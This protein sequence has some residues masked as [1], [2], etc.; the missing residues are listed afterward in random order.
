MPVLINQ[1][2]QLAENLPQESADQA[3]ASGSHQIPLF[4][5]DG[6]PVTAPINDAQHLLS[7]GYTQPSPDQLGDLLKHAKYSTVPEQIKTGLEGAASAAT[8]GASTGVERALGVNPED[9]QG[10]RETNPG[11]HTIGQMGGLVG[12][13][14]LAPEVSV[15]KG[16]T[17]TGEG[18]AAALGLGAEGAGLASRMAGG[19]VKAAV[20]N[21]LFQSGDEVSKLLSSDPHQSVE[22]AMSEIGLG[23]LIGAGIGAP[24]GAVSPLWKA[25]K[26]THLGQFLEDFK[27]RFKARLENPNPAEALTEEVSNY[28]KSVTSMA[29]EVYGA[30]GL[31]SRAIAEHLPEMSAKISEQV[32]G[33]GSK[34][35]TAIK[36]LKESEDPFAPRLEKSVS[37]WQSAVTDPNA[38]S[39]EIFDATQDLKQQLQEW[40]KYNKALA[41][42]SE[43]EFRDTAKGLAFELRTAL[44][45]SAVWGKSADVQKGINSAFKEYLPA[46]K[47]FEKRFTSL[48][49][50]ERVVDPGKINTY[51]NQ[52]GKPNAELKQEMLKN[53]IDASEKYKKVIGDTHANLGLE[54]P[55]EHS[56]LEHS[57]SSLEQVTPG[58]KLADALIN[59]GLA[60]LAGDTT[61]AVI[62]G[63]IGHTV[64]AGGIGA[65]IGEHA[66]GPFLSSVLPSIVKPLLEKPVFGEAFK[67]AVDLGVSVAK[68]EAALSKAA[69]A[70]FKSGQ[71]VIPQASMASTKARD[72]LKDR[73][74]DL[75]T[76]VA[77]LM[78]T[79]GQTGY[80]MPDHGSAMSTVAARSVNYLQSLKPNEEK[81]GP[82]DPPRQ[83]SQVEISKYNRALDIAEQPLSA[84]QHIKDGTLT[85][86]DVLTFKNLYPS[87]Y[88]SMSQKLMTNMI[89]HVSKG[90]SVP[91]S[92]RLSLSLFLG[93]PLDATMK[94]QSI[95]ATQPQNGMPTNPQAAPPSK[96]EH[97]MTALNKM[98]AQ[99][100]TP[101]QARE[102]ERISS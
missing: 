22:S 97:S 54:S 7:Q 58:A 14:F 38:K 3:L 11:V 37:K 63:A 60:R 93:Q 27:G 68:G 43:R 96:P 57:R 83:P 76:D 39:A 31:K 98:P 41:P 94:P 91:Y 102:A 77:S 5:P 4:D 18:T 29:D 56:A 85:P 64:G 44:E 25:A 19:A 50:N 59:K 62:G 1:G 92:A 45:D 15:S 10:R 24:L 75:K 66:L 67:S 36:G 9:I 90:G 8:L 16:L 23:G 101:G 42:L 79:G 80:Y 40:G 100:Q 52:V 72:R 95:M 26:E 84:I 99:Y 12:S 49:G 53:F 13:A 33:L 78:N 70:L 34:L 51:I 35:E 6:N 55:F 88:V 47:D 65:L 21:A 17:A 69:K 20:E 61:G 73:L 89:D 71:E 81:T 30:N 2:N 87:L 82:L 46:L 28:H 74:D 86:D 32:E 48:V